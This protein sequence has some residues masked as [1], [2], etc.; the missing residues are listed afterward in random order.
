MRKLPSSMNG[1]S[2]RLPDKIASAE[3]S[4]S[5]HTSISAPSTVKGQSSSGFS[6]VQGE[7]SATSAPEH[8]ATPPRSALKRKKRKAIKKRRLP[9]KELKGPSPPLEQ[10]YWNEFD[11]GSEGERDEPYTIF[12]DPTSPGAFP[13]AATVSHFATS[14]SISAKTSWKKTKTYLAHQRDENAGPHERSPLINDDLSPTSPTL[15]DSSDSDNETSAVVKNRSYSTMGPYNRHQARYARESVLSRCSIGCF[16]SSFVFVIVAAI[17][18]GTGRRKAALE[19]NIGVVVCV[20]ASAV[21]TIIGVGCTISRHDTL[22]WV[23]RSIMGSTLVLV[24]VANAAVVVGLSHAQA[25][26]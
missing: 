8:L 3:Q 9:A 26:K 17:L 19:V 20:A 18:V 2:G 6:P 25:A 23:H 5:R 4:S 15:E 12:V 14:I 21:S 7:S 1:S 16:V 11:D 10:R 22:S 13:G 24:I